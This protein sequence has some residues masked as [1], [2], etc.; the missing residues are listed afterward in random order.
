MTTVQKLLALVVCVGACFAA[1]ALG[2]YATSTSVQDWYP[3]LKKPAWNPPNSVFGPVWTV[4]YLA[5]GIAAWIVWTKA[6]FS[7]ARMPL[8][9]FAVQLLLNMAW[10]FFFFAFRNPGAAFVELCVLWVAISATLAAFWRVS[11]L[12]AG[13]L[14]P[15]LAWVTFAGVLNFTVW[16]LNKGG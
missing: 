1:A 2:G 3:T 14:V 8:A 11:I 15:Y 7:A 6:G 12:A 16:Q 10:S 5:M 9:L 13:L 4:L